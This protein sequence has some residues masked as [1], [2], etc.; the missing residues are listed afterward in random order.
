M[1][2]LQQGKKRIKCNKRRHAM[3]L[4]RILAFNRSFEKFTICAEN[5]QQKNNAQKVVFATASHTEAQL[6]ILNR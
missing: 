1:R 2:K 4:Y 5:P 3:V 6:G